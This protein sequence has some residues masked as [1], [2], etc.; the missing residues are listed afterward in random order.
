MARSGVLRDLGL[1]TG[2]PTGGGA[3]RGLN[4]QVDDGFA[5]VID[6][7]DARAVS[8]ARRFA[9]ERLREHGLEELS[10]D[11]QLVV[12]ELVTNALLHARPPIR[13]IVQ[14][15]PPRARIEVHDGSHAMPLPLN[16]DDDSMT[17]RGL[18]IAQG[19]STVWGAAPA[20]AGKVLWAE[21]EAGHETAWPVVGDLSHDDLIEAWLK[22]SEGTAEEVRHTIR[23]G[24]VPTELLLRAKSH[25]DDLVREFTLAAAGA[26][27]GMTSAVPTALAELIETVVH[28][29]TEARESLRR[30]ALVARDQ[31]QD[32]VQL[33]LTLPV[34][35]ADAAKEYL[36][37]LEEADAYCRAARLL[38][39]ET[40]PRHRVFRE[41]YVGELVEQLERA[42][43][44][45]PVEDANTFEEHLLSEIDSMAHTERLRARA[46]RLHELSMLLAGSGTPEAVATA[47]LQAS[48]NVLGARGGAVL[49][50][51][52][53]RQLVVPAAIGYDDGLVTAIQTESLSADLPGVSALRT[54]EEIWLES[55]SERDQRFPELTGMEPGTQSMAAVPLEVAGRRLGALRFSFHESRLFDDD[56]RDFVRAIA[57]QTAQALDRAYQATARSNA[58]EQLQRSL[59]P[60][61][62]PTVPGIKITAAYQP[63]TESLEVG[64]DFYDVWRCG[65]GRLMFALGDVSGHG[66]EAAA[67]TAL[68]RHTLRAL[69]LTTTDLAHI[70][71]K[72]DSALRENL[73][74]RDRFATVAFGMLSHDAQT[75]R[76]ELVSGGHQG[77]ALLR[78]GGTVEILPINGS[79]LGILDQPDISTC[80]VELERGDEVVLFTD[81][82]TESRNH[83]G[84]WFGIEG[85]IRAVRGPADNLLPTAN[86][87]GAA[88]LAHAHGELRD[89]FAVLA[90]KWIGC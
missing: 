5:L 76:L 22:D 8:Q 21:L 86:R 54:G 70:L 73:A 44:G 63:L 68:I 33:E 38:T 65:E 57:A 48:A 1:S 69:S 56:E 50:A 84:E 2:H 83:R 20:G 43:K 51:G 47:A 88:A 64:G 42:S 7:S 4:A 71:V 85:L 39:L 67:V 58:S 18:R 16:P 27:S 61:A 75:C 26:A 29:F 36:R 60:P 34:S 77:P 32:R 35:A 6:E 52:D 11:V 23:L 81:G 30:Q 82:I 25:V 24:E 15:S 19:L 17:G 72:L 59:L 37:A 3:R 40:P 28:G 53:D 10:V 78:A 79:L 66:A 9:E 87:V 13:L 41:W 89:D 74:G 49:L 31:H 90:M 62:L 46:A 12:T 45:L 55:P 80:A 14:V